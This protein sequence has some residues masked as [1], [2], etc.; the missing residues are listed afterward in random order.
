MLTWALLISSDLGARYWTLFNTPSCDTGLDRFRVGQLGWAKCDHQS[1]AY[2]FYT[3]NSSSSQSLVDRFGCWWYWWS[4]GI[5]GHPEL[6]AWISWD[7][8]ITW[9]QFS[10]E[11]FSF[12]LWSLSE[13]FPF[14]WVQFGS[15]SL[16][17][18]HV[19]S[20]VIC[21]PLSFHMMYSLFHLVTWS[22]ILSMSFFSWVCF[23][24]LVMMCIMLLIWDIFHLHHDHFDLAYH[25]GYWAYWPRIRRST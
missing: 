14:W 18:V 16:F 4:H 25:G 6:R 22:F 24:W 3:C 7:G 17:I 11:H 5:F 15:E 13:S 23:T 10:S 21:S 2:A 8:Y 20:P 1:P 9:L 12:W 19:E